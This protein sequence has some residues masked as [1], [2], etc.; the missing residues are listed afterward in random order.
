MK[1]NVMEEIG[2]IAKK[3]EA[4]A[5]SIR[6]EILSIVIA[7]REISWSKIKAILESRYG[8]INPNTLAFHIKKLIDCG[9]IRKG[10]TMESPI[11]TVANVPE[12]LKNELKEVV[13][14]YKQF[15]EGIRQ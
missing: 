10:G 9:L 12:E 7:F 6:V 2:E 5:N 4:L 14:F 8:K 13:E 11:Y 3:H 1:I 15:K